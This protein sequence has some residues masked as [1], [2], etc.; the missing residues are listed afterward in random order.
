M[1]EIR[2]VI[3]ESPFSGDVDANKAYLTRCLRDSL[4]RGEAPYASHGL[5]PGALNDDLPDER[6][7]GME[8]GFAWGVAAEAT[9]V[10]L[11]NGI[12]DGMRAGINRALDADRPIEYRKLYAAVSYQRCGVGWA[13]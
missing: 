3:L 5:Y 7:L 12:S 1:S 2:R 11:D 4:M 8:A 13:G 9:V 6:K 10:Y